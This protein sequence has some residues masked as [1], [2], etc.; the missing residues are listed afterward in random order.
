M[1]SLIKVQEIEPFLDPNNKRQRLYPIQYPDLWSEYQKHAA[2]N[3]AAKE[4]DLS[5][6]LNDWNNKLND[7]ERHYIKYGL[8]FFAGSDFIVNENQEKDTDEVTILEYNFFNADKIARENIH[9]ES[10]ADLIETYI[11]DDT[12][13]DLLLS[14]T[15]NIPSI[16]KKADWLRKYIINDTFVVRLVACAITEGIFFSGT[17]CAIFW[18]RKRALMPGLCDMNQLISIDEGLHRDFACLV[19]KKYIVNKL[20]ENVLIDMIKSAVEIEQEFCT[21]SLPV[22][23]IGMNDSLMRNYIEYVADHLCLNL[24]GKRIYNTENPF[25][26]MTMISMETKSDFFVHR[27]T[28]YSKQAILTDKKQNTINFDEDY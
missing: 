27:P 6:D 18:L 3:W 7:D 14:A 8:A 11:K 22:S 13:K 10:Y 2:A 24:I 15:Q 5:K 4:V 21:D 17:F 23:L 16:K 25:D 20:P 1:T 9:T 19:Y 12:E 26:W 28:S